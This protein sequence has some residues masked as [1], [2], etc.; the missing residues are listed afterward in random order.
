[1]PFRLAEIQEED[2]TAFALLDEAA[3]ADWPLARAMEQGKESRQEMFE[4]WFKSIFGKDAS[5][6]WMKAVDSETGEMAAG[7]LWRLIEPSTSQKKEEAADQAAKE[8]VGEDQEIP[9]VFIEMGRRWKEF[10]NDF[11][12]QQAFASKH[13]HFAAIT[14]IPP[15]PHPNQT[16]K[17]SSRTQNTNARA[18]AAC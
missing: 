7:A 5:A 16:F 13:A 18:R 6:R 2:C 15:D 14:R 11:I 17:C 1:M 4:Q 3:S 9:P 10:Q 8:S 12:G